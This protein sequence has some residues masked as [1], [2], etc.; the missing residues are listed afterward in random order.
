MTHKQTRIVF[1]AANPSDTDRLA[2]DREFNEVKQLLSQSVNRDGFVL[3]YSPAT[4]DDDLQQQLLDFAPDI[5][6]FSGHGEQDGL[7]FQ[8]NSNDTLFIHQDSLTDFFK[9]FKGRIRCLL[10]NACNSEPQAHAIAQ[11]L[12]YVIG[13]N[14]PIGDQAAII[15][16][17]GF[18]RALFSGESI[19]KAYQFGCSAIDLAGINEF[20]TPV[21]A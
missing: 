14:A 5:V 1:F 2:I 19:D 9:L 21:L 10:L 20:K 18:Y 3:N 13:M 11:H 6:H 8:N 4:G 16:A 17:K 7:Y 12:D 15:F